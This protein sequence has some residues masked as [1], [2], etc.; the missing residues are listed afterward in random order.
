MARERWGRLGGATRHDDIARYWRELADL[1]AAMPLDALAHAAELLLEC[2]ARDRVVFV[3]GNGGSAATASHLACDLAKGTR[4][5]SAPTFRVVPLT[6]SVPLLT[7]WANDTSYDRV[8]AE[9]LA[10]LARPGDL[11]VAISASGD[12]PN[13]VAAAETARR[14][15]ATTLALTGRTGGRLARLA[16]LTVRVPS[17][18][19]ELVEDAHLAAAHSLCVDLRER[20]AAEAHAVTVPH[21]VLAGPHLDP[22]AVDLT[23]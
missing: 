16:D 1:A 4:P 6:D 20:L 13:V 8:F 17:D 5:D 15:G 11:L 14:L 3:V 2:R 12:S 10:A 19:I 7:A 23:A 18:R 22:A 21:V 9:Q